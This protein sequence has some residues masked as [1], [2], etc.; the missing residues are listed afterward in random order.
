MHMNTLIIDTSYLMYRSY[1]ANPLLTSPSGKP[2]GA[3]FGFAKTVISLLEEYRPDALIFA[4]DTPHPTWR[5]HIH[6]AYK[7]GRPPLEDSMRQQIPVILDWCNAIT[8]NVYTCIGYEADDIIY[9]LAAQLLVENYGTGTVSRTDLQK[10]DDEVISISAAGKDVL[11]D[12][13]LNAIN[14]TRLV[15]KPNQNVHVFS[16]DR[17]LYQLFVFK[18]IDFIRPQKGLFKPGIFSQQNFIDEYG[19]EPAQW[20]DYKALVGDPSDNLQ[21]IRG[22]GPKTAIKMLNHVG[23]LYKLLKQIGVEEIELFQRGALVRQDLTA[24]VI[25]KSIE[26]EWLQRWILLIQENLPQLMQTYSLAGLSLVPELEHIQK[27]TN[28]VAGIEF[29]KEYGF[30]SLLKKI[31]PQVAAQADGDALF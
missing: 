30:S 8:N 7:A 12:E 11:T 6:T 23:S 2:A 25:Q 31:Q 17:D 5:H 15:E 3:F 14:N 10:L 27:D 19:L 22:I 26:E 29:F 9:T 28:L 20:L 1:F 4:T 24:D 21:G 18:H 16:S 13:H